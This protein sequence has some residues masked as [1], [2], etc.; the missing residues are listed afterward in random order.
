M[1]L[2][3]LDKIL[4]AKDHQRP[5]NLLGHKLKVVLTFK[6]LQSC[7][8]LAPVS[9]YPMSLIFLE[10]NLK[11]STFCTEALMILIL[12]EIVFLLLLEI[13]KK[14]KYLLCL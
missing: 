3:M 8:C 11:T 4:K 6:Q 13:M 14:Y 10:I 12:L 7:K 5:S 2:K 1:I 9:I